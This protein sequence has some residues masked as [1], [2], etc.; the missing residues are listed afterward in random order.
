ELF[1]EAGG[2]YAPIA[3][4]LRRLVGDRAIEQ[5]GDVGVEFQ[6]IAN[7]LERLALRITL[8][9]ELSERRHLLQAIAQAGQFARTH[10]AQRDP[11]RDAFEIWHPVQDAA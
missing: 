8:G 9:Y 7:G 6:V 1:V 3:D 4:L 5:R 10:G 11:R 2:Q